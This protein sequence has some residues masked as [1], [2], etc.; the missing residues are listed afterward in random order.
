MKFVIPTTILHWGVH[1]FPLKL[2][3]I[4]TDQGKRF[5]SN[6]VIEYLLNIQ[7]I[8][9]AVVFVLKLIIVLYRI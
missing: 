8:Y 4:W 1:W 7:R 5:Y 2:S 3:A 9:L 6:S